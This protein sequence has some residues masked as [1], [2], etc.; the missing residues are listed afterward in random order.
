MSSEMWYMYA[1]TRIEGQLPLSEW[2]LFTRHVRQ[3]ARRCSF[4]SRAKR[5]QVVERSQR[6]SFSL[7][8]PTLQFELCAFECTW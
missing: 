3:L 1:G 6:E 7:F 4:E 8:H 5:H 2:S